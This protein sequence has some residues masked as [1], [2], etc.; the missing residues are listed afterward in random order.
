VIN[1]KLVTYTLR[2]S[3]TLQKLEIVVI[4]EEMDFMDFFWYQLRTYWQRKDEKVK[5][6]N[7]YIAKLV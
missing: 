5:T 7:D 3:L 4:E 1:D 6:R 2:M